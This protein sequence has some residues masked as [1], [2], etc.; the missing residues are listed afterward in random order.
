MDILNNDINELMLINHPPLKCNVLTNYN[1]IK[2]IILIDINI[3]NSNDFFNNT[4]SSTFPI[5]YNSSNTSLELEAILNNF[6]SIDRLC[7]VFDEIYLSSVKLF[8]NNEQFFTEEDLTEDDIDNLSDN[9]KLLL[10]LYKKFNIKNVDYLACNSLNYPKWIQYYNKLNE[11]TKNVNNINGIIVG[12]S[13]DQTGNIKYGGDWVL[14]STGQD[15]KLVYFTNGITNYADTLSSGPYNIYGTNST[16]YIRQDISGYIYQS[17]DNSTWS[18]IDSWPCSVANI[19]S[20]GD[21]VTDP[22]KILTINFIADINI[23]NVYDS[24]NN[25]IVPAIVY[26]QCYSKY[27]TFDGKY[28]NTNVMMSM[29]DVSGGYLGLINNGNSSGSNSNITVKNINLSASASLLYY[30]DT[31][32]VT[33]GWICQA[34]FGRNSNNCIVSYCSSNALIKTTSTFYGGGGGILGDNSAALVDNCYSKGNIDICAGGIFGG[35]ACFGTNLCTATNCYSTGTIANSGGGIF[36]QLANINSTISNLCMATNC[37]STGLTIGTNAG[38]IFG[39]FANKSSS[40][41]GLC[42]AINCY[43]IGTIGTSA[44]GIFGYGANNLTSNSSSCIATNCYSIGATIGTNAGG[45]FGYW[46]NNASSSGSCTATNCYS[47]GA[48]GSNAGGIFATSSNYSSSSSST[49]CTATNCYTTGTIGGN[50]GGIFGRLSNASSSGSCTAI[51]CYTIGTITT[52]GTGIYGTAPSTGCIITNSINSNNNTWS[53]STANSYLQMTDLSNNLIWVNIYSSNNN[54]PFLLASFN[55]NFYN[56]IT[57]ET[58]LLVGAKTN[59]QITGTGNYFWLYDSNNYVSIDPSGNMMT[60]HSLTSYSVKILN[61]MTTRVPVYDISGTFPSIIYGYNIINF[62]LT[63]TS[64]ISNICFL[65]DTIIKTNQGYIPISEINSNYH[66]INNKKILAITQTM[67][68]EQQLICF[69]KDALGKNRP[70]RQLVTTNEHKIYYKG[71]LIPSIILLGLNKKIKKIKYN[72]EIL[73]NVLMNDY[74]LMEVNGIITE[75]LHPENIIAKLYIG[76]NIIEK[77]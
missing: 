33:G 53:Y 61:G 37:Y 26:F 68:Y 43:S 31:Y 4:N 47:T 70:N 12:A 46:A 7:F 11:L 44:G 55:N 77:I 14:E 51:N 21:V 58:N 3:K 35:R 49:F 56:N 15:I 8:L 40:S 28:N 72:G 22:S 67:T 29:S 69:E 74:N 50:A 16:K 9:F 17:P 32:F 23:S 62:T 75:T 34:F 73:Y 10:N 52:T 24:S 41:S 2:N 1:N 18:I 66:T 71:K 39:G 19:D 48:I 20:N 65:A 38:G 64:L 30:N 54:I 36:G 25:Y 45:I 57:S 27:I 42:M 63:T 5:I 6:T 60:N 13:N 59:Y 76:N